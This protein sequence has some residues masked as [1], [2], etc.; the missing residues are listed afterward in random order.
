MS[1][2][3]LLPTAADLVFAGKRK[4]RGVR[5]S[6]FRFANLEGAGVYERLFKGWES[7]ALLPLARLSAEARAIRLGLATDDELR[8]TAASEY[9]ARTTFDPTFAVGVAT[10]TRTG[11]ASGP[12]PK[13]TRFSRKANLQSSPQVKAAAFTSTVDVPVK[14][15]QLV[16][17]VPITAVSA[18]PEGN[19]PI[20]DTFDKIELDDPLFDPSFATTTDTYCAGGARDISDAALR[21]LAQASY[22]GDHAP[23]D[24]AL[25]LGAMLAG[26]RHVA[27][28]Q[29]PESGASELAIADESWAY[30]DAWGAL[31]KQVVNDTYVGFGCRADVIAVR[32]TYVTVAPTVLLRSGAFLSDTTVIDAAIRTALTSYFDDRT[33][34]YR[35]TTKGLRAAIS[36]AHPKILNCPDVVVRSSTGAVMT[37]PITS[38]QGR[39]SGAPLDVRHYYFGDRGLD[40]TY[41]PPS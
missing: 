26:T 3:R 20:F 8:D 21:L 7:Q 15:G 18:G 35:W 33:D 41:Q 11:G 2:R 34:W 32:N 30:S 23:V 10:L 22:A 17:A 16:V 6:A 28:F 37:E 31:V 19:V 38:R 9:R 39:T 24:T 27:T 5:P 40:A 25:A 29:N 14:A 4:L 1:T 36:R 13:G 12:I